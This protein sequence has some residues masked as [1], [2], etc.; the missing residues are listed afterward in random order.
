[1]VL[2]Y[3]AVEAGPPPLCI[4]PAL[5]VEHLDAI[6]EAPVRPLGL[7]RL[8]DELEAGG[9]ERPS[10][11]ITFDDGFAGVLE[12][13]VPALV[14][15]GIPA[16]IFCVAAHLGGRNDFATE[17]PSS[18]RLRL[19]DAR[20]LADLAGTGIEIGSH[21]MTHLPLSLAGDAEAEREVVA[22]RAALE[23]ATGAS[24]DWFAYPADPSP[25][26]RARALVESAYDGAAAGGNRRAD[27]H[28]D[29]W[30]VPRVEMHY[31]RRPPLLRR[32]LTGGDAYLALRRL[33]GRARRMLRSDYVA[34]R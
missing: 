34:P 4:G 28:F 27:R 9:P 32:A 3:H 33:G 10:V 31:L 20:A 21:G 25:G 6:R 24:V 30:A 19:A 13:A 1:M 23:D 29:R 16:T 7:A 26:P 22:S 12:H 5:F 11:A 14:E 17:P 2:C 18:P 15:R 8:A